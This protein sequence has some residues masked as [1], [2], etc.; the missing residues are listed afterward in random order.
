MKT[1]PRPIELEDGDD[2]MNYPEASKDSNEEELICA[3]ADALGF[4][5]REV[6]TKVRTPNVLPALK[7][8][9]WSLVEQKGYRFVSKSR[10]GEGLM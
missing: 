6:F 10:S 8:D 1:R 9:D 3:L 4:S 5:L 7:P 2:I